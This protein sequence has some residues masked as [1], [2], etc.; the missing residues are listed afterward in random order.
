MDVLHYVVA[1]VVGYLL[2]SIPT[3]L[4]VVWLTLGVDVRSIGSG[5][6]GGTNAYRA[7]G[8]GTGLATGLGDGLKGLLAVLIARALFGTPEAVIAGLA[9][10]VGHNWSLYLGFKGGAGTAPNLGALL[11]LSWITCV[12]ALLA[13]ALSAYVWRIASLAS[14][15]VSV[16]AMLILVGL[17]VAGVHPLS[18]LVYAVGQLALVA[19]ALAPNIRR[20]IAGKERPVT[21]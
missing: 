17:V 14:L 11:G 21:Y 19:L 8:W 4:V 1:A 3:G 16:A 5:R 13:G 10:V 15:T 6:T 12:L 2:G 9:A 18:Y 7:G 20:L